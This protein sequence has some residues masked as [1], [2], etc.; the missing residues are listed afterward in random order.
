MRAR[1]TRT[2]WRQ[3]QPS[4][5]PTSGRILVVH[6]SRHG[7]TAGLAEMMGMS[8]RSRGFAVVVSPADEIDELTGARAVVLG[9]ALYAGR[10][11]PSARQFARRHRHALRGLPVWLFSS[12]PLDGSAEEHAIPPTRQV[13]RVAASL[14]A[15]GHETFGGALDAAT[16][17]WVSGRMAQSMAGDF[18]DEAHVDRWAAAVAAELRELAATDP[19]TG[20]ESARP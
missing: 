3:K 19:T 20:M 11:V 14:G 17:G 7:A 1:T 4:A 13:Q 5:M 9:G 16:T 2:G 6:G 10:W 15:R 12:G 18:R 8:L